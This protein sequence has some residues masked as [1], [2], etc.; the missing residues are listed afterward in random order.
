MGCEARVYSRIF[1]QHPESLKK[2]TFGLVFPGN[3]VKERYFWEK[4]LFLSN[5][6]RGSVQ[7]PDIDF[8]WIIPWKLVHVKHLPHKAFLSQYH[9]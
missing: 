1:G 4:G 5:T 8:F 9:H 3:T 2:D 6:T 7:L